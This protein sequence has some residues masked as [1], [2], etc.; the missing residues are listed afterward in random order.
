[1]D[2]SERDEIKHLIDFGDNAESPSEE[3]SAPEA[4]AA[5]ETPEVLK[6]PTAPE[7]P[8][9]SEAPSALDGETKKITLPEIAEESNF[10]EDKD[11]VQADSEPY[12]SD[13]GIYPDDEEPDAEYDS[14]DLIDDE[15][16]GF[17]YEPDDDY[18]DEKKKPKS[19]T[20][21]IIRNI[22]IAAAIIAGVIMFIITDT[23]IIG[24]YK[25]NF[26]HNFSKIFG[27]PETPAVTES[28]PENGGIP[29]TEAGTVPEAIPANNGAE[30]G[31]SGEAVHTET[32]RDAADSGIANMEVEASVIIPYD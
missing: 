2:K 10:A 11:N 28:L 8:E 4:P 15:D 5:L 23:G 6:A 3:P 19:K 17:D 7:T 25:R 21:R 24:A 27:I 13:T 31:N 12:I 9:V 14:D 16:I 29:Y 20:A 30:S 26:K 1:M 32:D 22:I 18:E